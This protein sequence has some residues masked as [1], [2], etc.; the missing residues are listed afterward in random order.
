[1][2]HNRRIQIQPEYPYGYG[3]MPYPEEPETMP[4]DNP[5]VREVIAIHEKAIHDAWLA[6]VRDA[7][8]RRANSGKTS[9]QAVEIPI[10]KQRD[11]TND[12]EES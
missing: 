4:S 7:Q 2:K 1:M 8:E 6:V 3:Q 11:K 10:N 5:W 12:A 9:V